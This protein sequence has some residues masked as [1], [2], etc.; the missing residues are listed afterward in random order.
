MRL[1][2]QSVII[3]LPFCCAGIIV[4]SNKVTDFTL[5]V[6][7]LPLMAHISLFPFSWGRDV[8]IWFAAPHRVVGGERGTSVIFQ[9]HWE[10][11]WLK[12]TP[13]STYW[14][15]VLREGRGGRVTFLITSCMSGYYWDAKTSNLNIHDLFVFSW[16]WRYRCRVWQRFPTGV[17]RPEGVCER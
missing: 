16:C 14:D 17:E 2:L 5:E 11:M 7:F 13:P 1:C 15:I 3:Q 6:T 10:R 8:I 12:G 4:L 9:C